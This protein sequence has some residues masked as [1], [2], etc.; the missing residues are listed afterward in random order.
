MIEFGKTGRDEG[1][2]WSMANLQLVQTYV[3]NAGWVSVG[4]HSFN[5]RTTD[6]CGIVESRGSENIIGSASLKAE[7]TTMQI[8][9]LLHLKLKSIVDGAVF[10]KLKIIIICSAFALDFEHLV[11]FTTLN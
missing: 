11:S 4:A 8:I 6:D 3:I 1:I 9:M 10:N 7:V 2:Y 5:V